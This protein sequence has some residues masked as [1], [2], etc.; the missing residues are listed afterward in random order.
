MNIDAFWQI[1]NSAYVSLSLVI[2]AVSL[3]FLAMKKYS[4]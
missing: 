4:K 2:I 1:L 3:A